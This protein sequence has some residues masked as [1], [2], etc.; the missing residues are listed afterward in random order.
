MNVDTVH[1]SDKQLQ[2]FCQQAATICNSR[3]FKQLHKEM[4]KIYRKKG[5]RDATVIAFQDSLFCL[6]I[7]QHEGELKSQIQSF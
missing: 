4:V 3:E 7:E 6:Y 2:F 5:I 1:V